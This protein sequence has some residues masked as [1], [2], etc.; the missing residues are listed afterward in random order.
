MPGKSRS[1]APV[2]KTAPVKV[3]SK[4][5]TKAAPKAAPKQASRSRSRTPV[6]KAAPA[7]PRSSNKKRSTSRSTTPVKVAPKT[8]NV[9][10]FY[11]VGEDNS[12]LTAWA[13]KGTK[14]VTE[15]A[16]SLASSLNRSEESVRDR[17]KRYI[18][19][20]NQ[21]DVKRI[22][23][24]AKK[25]PNHHIHFVTDKQGGGS[26]TIGNICADDP[27]VNLKN[28]SSH[29]KA[30]VSSKSPVKERTPTP[31][32]AR[33]SSNKKAS[34]SP[35]PKVAVSKS[36]APKS[37]SPKAKVVAAKFLVKRQP[38]KRVSTTNLSRS[39]SK[40]TTPVKSQKKVKGGRSQSKGKSAKKR[41][42]GNVDGNLMSRVDSFLDTMNSKAAYDVRRNAQVLAQFV[43]G[44][45][46]NFGVEVNDVQSSC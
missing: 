14:T 38:A 42:H 9:R 23:A 24:A 7:K 26:K 44:F 28:A 13:A 33:A 40:N 43:R 1:P 22:S 17:V 10:K 36:P 18:S 8:T 11:T 35:A 45:S 16:K 41:D 46:S 2:K 30:K 15:L 32:K 4:K 39:Q 5:V 31:T 37:P 19:K 6:K 12:I 27:T 3:A 29:K 34:R 21:T 20:L 25:T